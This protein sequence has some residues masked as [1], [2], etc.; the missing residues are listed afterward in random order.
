M[1]LRIP[2]DGNAPT[3]FVVACDT[4][5]FVRALTSR[6][7]NYEVSLD[8]TPLLPTYRLKVVNGGKML[9]VKLR[10]TLSSL[11]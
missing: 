6:N 9:A 7:E 3:P 2:R 4:R 11:P 10:T 5:E 1:L 8:S